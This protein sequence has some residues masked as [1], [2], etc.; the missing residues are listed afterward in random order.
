MPQMLSNSAKAGLGGGAA[1]A[2]GTRV[3]EAYNDYK[4]GDNGS[5]IRNGVI[6]LIQLVV[7]ISVGKKYLAGRVAQMNSKE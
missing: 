3:F 1:L 2:G 5:A 7:G 4:K 6:G